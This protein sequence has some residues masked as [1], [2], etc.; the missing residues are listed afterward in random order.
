MTNM[1]FR[2]A[3]L[4]LVASGYGEEWAPNASSAKN[5]FRDPSI[6]YRAK[7]RYW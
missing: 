1:L 2:L 6:E 3:L 7:F 4:A 5:Q